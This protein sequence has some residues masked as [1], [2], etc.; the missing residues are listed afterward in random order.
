MEQFFLVPI[1]VYN[2]SNNPTIVTKQELSKYKSEKTPTYQ[3]DLLKK[4]ITDTVP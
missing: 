4:K 3:K 2:R 1:S